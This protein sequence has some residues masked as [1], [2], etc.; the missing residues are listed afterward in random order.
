[1]LC[2]IEGL[3]GTI[4]THLKSWVQLIS[5]TPVE[6]GRPKTFGPARGAKT[7]GSK[8]QVLVKY[9]G[10]PTGVHIP[11]HKLVLSGGC[12]PFRVMVL[13]GQH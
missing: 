12:L 1:M 5:V 7:A 6:T 3:N 11:M 2:K 13:D 8:L 4:S 10:T 9:S